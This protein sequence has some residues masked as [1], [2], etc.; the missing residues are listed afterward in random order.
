MAG[1]QSFSCDVAVIGAGPAG[2]VAAL[3]AADLGAKT[4]LVSRGDFGGMAANDGPVPVRT[5]AHA[6][7][8]MRDTAQLPRYGISATATVLDY[9]AL[10]ARVREVV[11]VARAQSSFRRQLDELGV[12]VRENAGSARFIDPHTVDLERGASL[13]AQTFI[14]CTGGKSRRLP[15]PG[16]EMTLTHSDAWSLKAV[17]PSMLVIGAGAT[18]VQVASIFHAFGSRVKLLQAGPRILPTEDEDV[19]AEV[20]AA[21]RAAGVEV[22][23]N[24]G[25]IERFERVPGGVRMTFGR[26]GERHSAEAELA[27]AAVGWVADTEEL[28]PAA[29]GIA[30][31]DRGFVKV[32]AQLRT[33]AAHVFAAGDAIGRMMLVPQAIQ[34]GFIAATNAVQGPSLAV[35]AQAAPTGSFTDPEYAQVGLTEAKAR[36][37]QRVVTGIIRFDSTARTIID[38]RTYGFCKLV[39]A[40]SDGRILGCHIVGER[41]VEIAQLAALAIAGDL[42]V[43]VLARVPLSYPTYGAVLGRVAAK[44]ARELAGRVAAEYFQPN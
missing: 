6:A 44:V 23:E 34:G 31:D 1:K 43:D 32:D 11:V 24:F 38:G 42:T 8:L 28:A 39:V 13:R 10:L 5:L 19:S 15:I 29:A 9:G 20:A 40:Q 27:V 17:P 36:G 14:L 22:V 30:L 33:S 18:G 35:E 21:F 7:R 3:R 16:F 4:T 12:E 37:S 41:A 26:D 2:V 25:A